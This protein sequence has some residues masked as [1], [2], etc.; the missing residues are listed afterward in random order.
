MNK[1]IMIGIVVIV[2]VIAGLGWF[3]MQGQTPPATTEAPAGTMEQIAM[4]SDSAMMASPAGAME[5]T[6]SAAEGTTEFTVTGTNFKF[7]V[8][9]IR[10]KAGDTVTIKFVNAGGFHDLVIDEFDVATKQ[11][12]GPTEETVT[13]VA[14]KAG[15]YEYYCSVGQHRAMGMKGNLIVE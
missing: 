1:N 10:V 11:T 5:S 4:P 15:T 3:M 12:T 2:L 13:F 9:E 7:D 14:D 6:G 8:P